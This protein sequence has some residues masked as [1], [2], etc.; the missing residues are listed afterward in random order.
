MQGQWNHG[1]PYYRCKNPGQPGNDAHP[2]SI[3]V[4]EEALVPGLDGWLCTLFDDEHID[5]TAAVLAGADR[6]DAEVEA[7][8]AEIRDRIRD[9]DRRLQN[10]RAA[11]DEA[12]EVA[13]IAKWIAEVERERRGYEA[14]LGRDVPAAS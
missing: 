14:T 6:P 11:L 9:C 5:S 4:R 10:Y 2:K 7:R 13:T 1:Q 8:Q 12:G 3:Y